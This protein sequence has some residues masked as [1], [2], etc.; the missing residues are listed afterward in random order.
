MAIVEAQADPNDGVL[1]AQA[2]KY[3]P[4]GEV[5]VPPPNAD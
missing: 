4:S 3:A 2:W 1:F 5:T